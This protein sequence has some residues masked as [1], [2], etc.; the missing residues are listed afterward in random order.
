MNLKRCDNLNSQRS[1][2]IRPRYL[3]FDLELHHF[4]SSLPTRIDPI[5]RRLNPRTGL[6]GRQLSL[7]I[8]R[9]SSFAPPS[10]NS[11]PLREPL[12]NTCHG[13]AS[14]DVSPNSRKRSHQTT[15]D[16]NIRV[17]LHVDNVDTN[18]LKPVLRKTLGPQLKESLSGDYEGLIIASIGEK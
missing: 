11:P 7:H 6:R 17:P 18:H 8:P 5:D 2:S 14:I 12:N 3:G 10:R 13:K 16:D 15:T 4:G 1:P 9:I